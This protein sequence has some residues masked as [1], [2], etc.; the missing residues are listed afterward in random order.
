VE[1]Y[2][3]GGSTAYSAA[4]EYAPY[5]PASAP[6]GAEYGSFEDEPPLLEGIIS[7]D[8]FLLVALMKWSAS[9]SSAFAA[10]ASILADQVCSLA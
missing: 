9:Y 2:D 1:W 10:V 3:T 7:V 6:S 5:N 8:L 4:N